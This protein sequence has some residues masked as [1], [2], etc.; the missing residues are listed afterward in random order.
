MWFV[1]K[2]HPVLLVGEGDVVV[3]RAAVEPR[4]WLDSQHSVTAVGSQAICRPWSLQRTQFLFFWLEKH[5]SA[6]S[7]TL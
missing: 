7:K 4:V 5:F 2:T 1:Q 3:F 6:L